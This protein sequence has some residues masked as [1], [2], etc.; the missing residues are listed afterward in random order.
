MNIDDL[1]ALLRKEH[2]V[3]L[4]GAFILY[5]TSTLRDKQMAIMAAQ[6]LAAEDGRL[7]KLEELD[8]LGLANEVIGTAFFDIIEQVF[9]E[10]FLDDYVEGKETVTGEKVAISHAIN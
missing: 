2:S 3:K 8:H 10:K 5:I 4:T 6:E 1:T 9:G 7:D